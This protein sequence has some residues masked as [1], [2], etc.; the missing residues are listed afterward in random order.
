MCPGCGAVVRSGDRFCAMCGAPVSPGTATQGAGRQ[1]VSGERKVVT[2]L[3]ADTVDSTRLIE[4]FDPEQAVARLQPVLDAMTAAV[5]TY[6]GIVSSVMGDGVLALFGA[7]VAHEDH[8]VR[9][10]YAAL[11]MLAD[12]R[13][14]TGRAI[15][16]RVG[17]HT[18]EVLLRTIETDLSRDYTALGP[19]V[20]LASRME[21]MAE[22]GQALLT[23]H[24]VRLAQGFVDTECL[25]SMPVRGL[26]EPVEVHRL[27][28][29][30]GVVGTWTPRV[31][32]EL[33]PFIGRDRELATLRDGLERARRGTGAVTAIV[34]EAGVG[35]SRLVHEFLR[36]APADV[37]RRR[38]QASPYDASTPYHPMIALLLG[39]ADG[40]DD[41]DRKTV[42]GRVAATVT[43]MA[44]T[45]GAAVIDPLVAM[46]GGEPDSAEWAALDP[47][48]RRR[49]I[50]D[51]VRT[52]IGQAA[53][54]RTELIV[55]E[56]LHWIDEDT[57]AVLDDVVAAAV[58]AA[59]HLVVTY[60]PMYHDRWIDRSHHDQVRLDPLH[61]DAADDL[62]GALLGRHP[63]VAR[64]HRALLAR[65]D[66]TP[67]FVEETVRSLSDAGALTG[68]A[69]AHR[70]VGDPDALALPDT[71]HAVVAARVDQLA[72]HDKHLLQ[73]AAVIGETVPVD[74]LTSTSGLDAAAVAE[75]AARLRA[76]QFVYELESRR[77]LVF[78]HNLIREVVYGQIPLDSRRR[79]HGA[80]AD[81]LATRT[82]TGEAPVERLAHHTYNAGRWRAA[83]QHLWLAAQRSEQRS[84]YPQAQ[85]LLTMGLDAASRLAATAETQSLQIDMA[86]GLR[87]AATGSG[88]RLGSTLEH[89]DRAAVHAD[90]LGDDRRRAMVAVHR[91]YVGSLTGDHPLA[92][93]A[94]RTVQQVGRELGDRYLLAEGRLAEGQALAM[95][96]H[97]RDVPD[98]LG[99][100]VEFLRTAVGTDRRGLV[101]SRI[102]TSLTFISFAHAQMGQSALA[103]HWF[104][105]RS[106]IADAG[107][108][109][110][111]LA[112]GAW[113]GGVIE[114]QAGR[115]AAAAEQFDAGLAIT[116]LHDLMYTDALISAFAGHA[117]ALLG[118]LGSAER[119]VDWAIESARV[120]ESPLIAE[121]ARVHRAHG[122][123]QRGDPELARADAEAV[124]GFARRRDHPWLEATA[125]RW[126]AAAT[127]DR[128]LADAQLQTAIS[129]C[130]RV[131]LAATAEHLRSD[132]AALRG[133]GA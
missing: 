119:A 86:G 16:I 104:A 116:R 39:E 67:L 46:V 35:K 90:E 24:T 60:R 96:G 12:V 36:D 133:Q 91:S 44:P 118:E 23:A 97:P 106:A 59:I 18:G 109:P 93:S 125:L 26:D 84:A 131:H 48:R 72:A 65:T 122:H 113:C 27:V 95:A 8:A 108:R 14:A 11:D 62:V 77:E 13:A 63:S 2:V 22:P 73:V 110:F 87:V 52:V 89:L 7:P 51:A 68:D 88:Q 114:L 38:M 102:V 37:T 10:A 75:R 100:D 29:R 132:V 92:V 127:T 4:D 40:H 115:P 20:H 101:T 111:E 117:W 128:D 130:E 79:L 9:A 69:G 21:R 129:V 56:D 34:G 54:R 19:A 98:L 42:R 32:R 70:F 105:E 30:T 121:W 80:V 50:R 31:Q 49:R 28:R 76:A 81:A 126:L 41:L 45:A 66:G 53:R 58:D 57:Q 74:V 83:A 71:V 124:L 123:L 3:F 17:V 25:G 82:P 5:H 103:D 78:K 85:R 1:A 99:L 47:P 107:G 6:D 33:T 94:A 43:T 120:M 15:D 112:F 64:L 55:V 61:D